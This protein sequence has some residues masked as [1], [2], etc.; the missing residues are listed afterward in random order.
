LPRIS[1]WVLHQ[2][3]DQCWGALARGSA[4]RAPRAAA[5]RPAD[6]IVAIDAALHRYARAYFGALAAAAA[7]Q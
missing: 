5:A 7:E 6:D 2:R 4:V 1:T 3:P